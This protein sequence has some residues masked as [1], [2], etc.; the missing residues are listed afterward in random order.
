MHV[1]ACFCAAFLSFFFFVPLVTEK[2]VLA[3][4]NWF[5]PANGVWSTRLLV[6]I[7]NTWN[8]FI[9]SLVSFFSHLSS[10]LSS[11]FV[12]KFWRMTRN[13][14]K[15]SKFKQAMKA[16]QGMV[17]FWSQRMPH[18]PQGDQRLLQLETRYRS[19]SPKISKEKLYHHKIWKCRIT[20]WWLACLC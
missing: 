20:E 15:L 5:W 3:S 9:Q 4:K 11:C 13:F 7:H 17:Y 19:W 2:V 14:Q 18:Y 10:F 12:K 6:E 8:T 1:F 16:L